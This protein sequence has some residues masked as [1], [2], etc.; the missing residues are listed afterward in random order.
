MKKELLT[1]LGDPKGIPFPKIDDCIQYSLLF[2]YFTKRFY[3]ISYTLTQFELKTTPFT[4]VISTH[5]CSKLQLFQKCPFE[6]QPLHFDFE[7]DKY[8]LEKAHTLNSDETII[9]DNIIS[10][11][12]NTNK[13]GTEI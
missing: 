4:T 1:R 6:T 8:S 7:F 10:P 2:P 13:V 12:I 9:E 5:A 11:N 3:Y